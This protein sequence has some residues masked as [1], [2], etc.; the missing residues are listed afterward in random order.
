MNFNTALELQSDLQPAF[1][2]QISNDLNDYGWSVIDNYV[3]ESLLLKLLSESVIL[4][5]SGKFRPAAISNDII[6][7][8]ERSDLISW[9][10]PDDCLSAQRDLLQNLNNLR[11]HLNRENYLGLFDLEM[12]STIYPTGSFYKKH[13][14]NRHHSNRRILT[15][16]LYL[17]IEW[18]AQDGGQLR[19]YLP[20]KTIDIPPI[21]GRLVTFLS[22]SYHHEVLPT[23]LDRFSL[24]GWFRSSELHLGQ[25]RYLSEHHSNKKA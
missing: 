23:R 20:K 12:H 3:P 24:T 22:D 4:R 16:I 2:Q 25:P 13:L 19:L 8:N 14:D 7:I 1:N 6:D 18:Q 10:N 5:D 9:I 15:F 21:G 17:N 11:H